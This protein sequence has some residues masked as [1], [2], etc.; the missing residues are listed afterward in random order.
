MIFQLI[1]ASSA[2]KLFSPGELFEMLASFR[3]KNLRLKLTGLLLYKQGSFMQAIE[4]DED[5][6]R[7]L[8][9]EI[10]EDPRHH[11]VSTLAAIG[12]AERQFP[13]WSMGFE[14]LGDTNIGLVPGYDPDLKFPSIGDELPWKTAVA[15]RLPSTF[16]R[17]E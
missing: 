10:R 2:A 15:L 7:G 11:G 17:K 12:I 6:V 3:E 13:K 1:Y 4:G 5:T 8:Y 16:M 9:D 14:N